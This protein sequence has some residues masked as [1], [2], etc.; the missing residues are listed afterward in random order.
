MLKLYYFQLQY[1]DNPA[2][3]SSRGTTGITTIVNDLKLAKIFFLRAIAI[4]L[5]PRRKECKALKS[6]IS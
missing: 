5:F 2:V 1:W 3:C 6:D 4:T